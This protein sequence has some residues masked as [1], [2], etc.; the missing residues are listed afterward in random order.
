MIDDIYG[1]MAFYPYPKRIWRKMESSSSIF[2]VGNGEVYMSTIRR[3]R[4]QSFRTIWRRMVYSVKGSSP[5]H[6][7]VL[8]DFKRLGRP[9]LVFFISAGNMDSMVNHLPCR[10]TAGRRIYIRPAVKLES[11]RSVLRS[12]CK[13]RIREGFMGKCTG[14]KYR[15]V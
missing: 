1:M 3:L 4:M 2:Y 8:R 10:N 9:R 15:R 13:E 6:P 12:L 7:Q 14:R 5:S 11:V